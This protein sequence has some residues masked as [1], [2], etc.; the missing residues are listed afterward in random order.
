MASARAAAMAAATVVAAGVVGYACLYQGTDPDEQHTDLFDDTTT[1]GDSAGGDT[2]T[3]TDTGTDTGTGT[4][5]DTDDTAG[6][7]ARLDLDPLDGPV[8]P[9]LTL[10]DLDSV[11]LSALPG[12]D[13]T[14]LLFGFP[15][16]VEGDT[17]FVEFSEK[18]TTTGLCRAVGDLDRGGSDVQT[19]CFTPT[20]DA[21][22]PLDVEGGPPPRTV[23]V[24]V[25]WDGTR[26]VVALDDTTSATADRFLFGSG[27]TFVALNPDGSLQEPVTRWVGVADTDEVFDLLGGLTD[28]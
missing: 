19:G 11:T 20:F 4:G 1:A 26:A 13:R 16:E 15:S 10:Y 17:L 3:G 21:G 25:L 28:H 23:A 2:G 5:T 18:G 27:P 12:S 9:L 8:D 7:E 24:P 14:L 6:G 22:G